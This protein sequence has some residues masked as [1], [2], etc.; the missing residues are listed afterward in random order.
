MPY[1]M[2]TKDFLKAVLQGHKKLKKISDVKFINVPPFAEIAVKN[3][4]SDVVKQP[5]MIDFFPD[6]LPKGCQSDRSYFYNIW[7]TKYPEQVKEVID[8]ANSVR[9]STNNESVR[10]NAIT[11]TDE[12]EE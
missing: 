10:Q 5:E 12:W 7:N 6:K 11:I 3:V 4:Y 9:Y 1:K 8:H 2:V